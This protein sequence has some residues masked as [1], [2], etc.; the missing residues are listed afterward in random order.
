MR[1]VDL[2]TTFQTKLGPSLSLK[3]RVWC[4]QPQQPQQLPPSQQQRQATMA[5]LAA[6]PAKM[7]KVLPPVLDKPAASAGADEVVAQDVDV[8]TD[9]VM[10]LA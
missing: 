6:S 5:K 1:R 8:E 3:R 7:L 10:E 4:L 2:K 9:A